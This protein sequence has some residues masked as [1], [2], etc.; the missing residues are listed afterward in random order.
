MTKVNYLANRRDEVVTCGHSVCQWDGMD[1]SKLLSGKLI[2]QRENV[3][4]IAMI[5]IAD[6]VSSHQY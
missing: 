3:Q 1:F 6:F 5:N 2:V 4:M